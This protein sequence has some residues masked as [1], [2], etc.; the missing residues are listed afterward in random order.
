MFDDAG[1][2]G[3]VPGSLRAN[4]ASV[5]ASRLAASSGLSSVPGGSTTVFCLTYELTRGTNVSAGLTSTE[6]PE[7][8]SV[9]DGFAPTV[10]DVANGAVSQA[11][12][13]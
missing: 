3:A 10:S 7:S 6:M 5:Q 1:H 12:G 4:C 9:L 8:E 2:D 13:V 11:V